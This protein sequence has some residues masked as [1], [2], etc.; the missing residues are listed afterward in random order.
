[1]EVRSGSEVAPAR[2]RD[3]NQGRDRVLVLRA[4]HRRIH[5]LCARSLQRLL[6]LGKR[7]LVLEAVVVALADQLEDLGVGR[8]GE[9]EQ[10]LQ[11]VLTAELKVRLSESGLCEQSR[12]LE[13]GG[14]RLCGVPALTYGVAHAPEQIG[15]PCRFA[16]EHVAPERP[17]RTAA[18]CGER[19]AGE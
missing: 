13:I 2:G 1:M 11:R 9:L 7:R 16:G 5:R 19:A 12:A 18:A 15:C 8:D 14:A 10:L 4:Q 6:G 17:T 3:S